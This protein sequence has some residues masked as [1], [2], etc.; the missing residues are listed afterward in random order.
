MGICKLCLQEKVLIKRSHLFP[1]FLYKGIGDEKNRMF[2]ISSSDPIRKKTV[3]SGAYEEHI[4]CADCDNNILS[5]LERY[6]NNN[7]YSQSFRQENEN[8]EQITNVHGINAIRCKNIDYKQF[9]LFLQSLVWRAS[10]S[11]HELFSNFK[12]SSEQEEELRASLFNSM[13]LEEN[14]YA[15]LIMTHQNEE[16]AM[17]DLVFINPNNPKK[18]SFFINQFIYLFHIDKTTVDDAVS[19]ISLSRK[20][21]MGITKLPEG[22][23]SKLRASVFNGVAEL[24]KKNLDRK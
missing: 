23:W 14:E 3:Q 11:E 2:E 9:K 4:L 12:L 15:C 10:V 8:F 6:T 19:Q 20:N 1:N 24:A 5:K 17:T 16:E 18:V 22:E 7:L 13:P 21:E